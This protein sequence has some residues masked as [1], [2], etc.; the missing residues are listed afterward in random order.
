MEGDSFFN[1]VACLGALL[2]GSSGHLSRSVFPR[3]GCFPVPQGTFKCL[4]QN[5]QRRIVISIQYHATTST[6]MCAY[7]QGLLDECSTCAT[8]L[9]SE[10][11]CYCNDWNGMHPSIGV[12][13][14]E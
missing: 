6:D 10:L 13:P 8:H 12:Q 11:R 14:G 2:L 9:T 3:T 5:I 1:Q 7:A 4:C